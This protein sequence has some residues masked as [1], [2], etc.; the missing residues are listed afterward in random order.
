MVGFSCPKCSSALKRHQARPSGEIECQ[1][2]GARLKLNE[3]ELL[4]FILYFTTSGLFLL[5]LFFTIPLLGTV[6]YV[7]SF[8]LFLVLN[9]AV[10]SLTSRVKDL[11]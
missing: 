1:T 7:A 11:S 6:G 4:A 2:C 5:S 3:N 8:V 10:T 9:V